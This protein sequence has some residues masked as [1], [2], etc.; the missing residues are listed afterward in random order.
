MVI[1]VIRTPVWHT[2]GV[3]AQEARLGPQ[4]RLV[5]PAPARRALGLH[6]GDVLA[7]RVEADHL[8]LEHRAAVLARLRK[9]F[10]S[11]PRNVSLVDELLADR[12]EEARRE[13]SE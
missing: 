1:R 2:S 3:V 11:I 5:I 10:A 9:Q 13:Q 4:G 12:R 6:A 8:V 7:V